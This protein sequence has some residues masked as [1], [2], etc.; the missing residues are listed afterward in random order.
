MEGSSFPSILSLITFLIIAFVIVKHLLDQSTEKTKR[1]IDEMVEE[2]KRLFEQTQVIQNPLKPF[3]EEETADPLKRQDPDFFQELERKLQW[4]GEDLNALFTEELQSMGYDVE[5]KNSQAYMKVLM[6]TVTSKT[7]FFH[8]L[9]VYHFEDVLKNKDTL[10]IKALSFH[11]LKFNLSILLDQNKK[12]FHYFKGT[13]DS[14][15]KFKLDSSDYGDLHSVVS[16]EL[17][18]RLKAVYKETQSFFLLPQEEV[19]KFFKVSKEPKKIFRELSLHYHPDK[20]PWRYVPSEEKNRLEK[21]YS[22]FYAFIQK[23][24]SGNV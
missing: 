7:D 15:F 20:I 22:D 10:T 16:P 24:Y 8:S 1:S 19:E 11:E 12:L 2:K 23:V 17:I 13:K 4:G 21:I 18:D 5:L 3:L 14:V 6:P 9:L